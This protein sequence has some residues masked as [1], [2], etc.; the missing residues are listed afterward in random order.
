MTSMH[1]F[2]DAIGEGRIGIFPAKN[3][4][5]LVGSGAQDYYAQTCEHVRTLKNKKLAKPL[6]RVAT[7]EMVLG[8]VERHAP[9]SFTLV[10]RC[11]DEP[12]LWSVVTTD[13]LE[14]SHAI[15][16]VSFAP[17]R[18]PHELKVVCALDAPIIASSANISGHPTPYRVEDISPQLLGNVDFVHDIG[19]LCPESDYGVVRLPDLF[20]HRTSPRLE[21]IL[22]GI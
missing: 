15:P 8:M 3:G 22:A 10:E 12:I 19:P 21:Q 5:M 6:A 18:N 7:A 13:Y 20:V 1:K 4:Y 9:A 2:I 14:P 11:I 17:A 16:E